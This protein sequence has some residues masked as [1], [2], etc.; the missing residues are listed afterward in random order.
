MRITGL[1]VEGYGVWSGLKLDGLSEGLNVLFGPNEAGK[2]TLMQFL[3]S[4]FYGFSPERRRY[5][6]PLRGSRAGGAVEVVAEAGR[7]RISRYDNPEEPGGPDL[8]TLAAA[9]GTRQG[10]HFLKTL[11]GNIDEKTFNNVFAVGLRQLQE[12]AALSDTEAASLLYNLSIGLDRVSLVDVMREL[13]K[14]RNRIL[15]AEGG[16]CQ[17]NELLAERERLQAEVERAAAS[18]RRYTR[19]AAE[20]D[21]L[22]REVLRLQEEAEALAQQ[23][24]VLD[25]AAGLRDRWQRREALRGELSALGP[26]AG[27]SEKILE[28]LEAVRLRLQ[29]HQRRLD[30]CKAQ[31]GQLGREAADLKING[32]LWRLGPRIEGLQ[33]Q[34]QW[35]SSLESRIEQL[36]LEI[37][38]L[39]SQWEGHCQRLG[40]GGA[41]APALP[42]VS[43]S[44]LAALRQPARALRRRL[45]RFDKARQEAA[46]ARQASQSLAERIKAALDARGETA[47]SE[48]VDR[49]GSLVAQLR[50]RA[51]LDQRLE[52]MDQYRVQLEDQCRYLLDRQLMPIWTVLALGAVFVVGV[53]LLMAGLFMPKSI[54]GSLGWLM[55]LI[56]LA[57]TGGAAVLRLAMERS[58]ARRLEACQKQI[59]MLQ[60]QA[61][62]AREE[63]DALD[64]QLSGEGPVAARLKAA[65]EELAGLEELVP[66]DSQR[67]AALTQ[68]ELAERRAAEAERELEAARRRWAAALAAA[69]LPQDLEPKQ[70]KELAASFDQSSEIQRKLAM[71][72]EELDQRRRE[73]SGVTSRIAQLAA[74]ANV[75]VPNGRPLDQLREMLRQLGEQEIR[76]KRRRALRRQL[77]KLRRR[78]AKLE[79]ALAKCRRRR[80]QLLHRAGATSEEQLR[81]QFQQYQQSAAVRHELE[82]LDREISAALAGQCSEEAIREC[83]EGTAGDTLDTRRNHADDRLQ[84]ITRKLHDRLEQRGRLREQMSLLAQDREALLKQLE[85]SV[86]EKRLDEAVHRWQ[87]LAVASRIL[88]A[89]RRTYEQQRQPESLKA[90]SGYLRRL[91]LGRYSRV[92]TPFGQEALL[93]DS[94]EG[95]SL[96]VEELSQG[97]REQLFLCLRLALARCYARRGASLPMILDDVLVNF[98]QKRAH[99][100]A[101]VLRDVAAA[102]QQLLV[103]TCHEHLARIFKALRVDVRRLPDYAEPGLSAKPQESPKR[104]RKGR[105]DP[106]RPT[107]R[108]VAGPEAAESP[109]IEHSEQP[110]RPPAA[111]PADPAGYSAWQ[112]RDGIEV[113]ACF[114]EDAALLAQPTAEPSQHASERSPDE[115][116]E[117]AEAA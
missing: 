101:A 9:D 34:Q 40:L 111:K 68:A 74:E 114:G 17:V 14:S 37:L 18:A 60:L 72:R 94:A 24:R 100:A 112:E 108:V 27:P 103:F 20:Q 26:T 19:L 80:R 83:L 91:T 7:F 78:R 115:H 31:R 4:V 2:T 22:D 3:R 110:Q 77:L 30:A 96:A 70:V 45:A 49:R 63:R 71:R 53:V 51:Q 8:L 65:E 89:I 35:I 66:L 109:D 117:G 102:G 54:T 59:N 86:V 28:R 25:L 95:R 76:R 90:A 98:D 15:D 73:L 79:A 46:S 64:K 106:D 13:A 67:Q 61:K 47:L 97:A 29:S 38:E 75:V 6:P 116:A 48:A 41:K 92:W 107:H 39:E 44:A 85:L 21:S 5:L 82:L 105:P 43:P 23:L 32:A 87:V 33:E 42:A 62:Q 93:V 88:E 81:R 12:L 50:R 10:E 11:L 56:G 36:E 104:L 58:N 55:A 99:A 113:E 57:G 84:A 69:G 52:K 16:A 1:E